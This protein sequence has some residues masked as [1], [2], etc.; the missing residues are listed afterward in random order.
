MN[1]VT[2][3]FLKSIFASAALLALAACNDGGDVQ[4]DAAPA[5]GVM[6]ER[7]ESFRTNDS[8]DRSES[9]PPVE[10]GEQ[11][12]AML[13]Y[14]YSMGVEAP[15]G[16]VS[17]LKDAHEAVC[18]SAG[19]N[20]C[21]VL[22]SSVN[23]WDDDHISANLNLRAAPEWLATFRETIVSDADEAGGRITSNSVN[24]EDLTTYII[25]LDARLAAKLALRDR[26]KNLLE[27]QEGSLSDILAAERALADVQGEIDSMNAQ[28]A[29]ARARVSMSML[30]ISYRSDPT[31]SSGVFKPLR[32]AVK[33]FFR[34]SVASL[35]EAVDFVAR[36][37][38]FFL[39][40]LGVLFILRRWWRGRRAGA[41]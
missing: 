2:Q 11:A 37:W 12:G 30:S 31:T 26:I 1:R 36:A 35:A 8:P 24:A 34:T 9:A 7:S 40:A 25:D 27:T 33:G 20:V 4:Y 18:M 16:A 14:S 10:P 38:P 39:I 23:S 15:K 3:P 29:A 5:A 28:L 17:A 13:A 21:Q 32:E 22:G 19:P 41:R 6:A